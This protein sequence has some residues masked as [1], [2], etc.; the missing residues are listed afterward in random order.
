VSACTS[1][2]DA[3]S[4]SCAA[5]FCTIHFYGNLLFDTDGHFWVSAMVADGGSTSHVETIRSTGITGVPAT[6]FLTWGNAGCDG[7]TAGACNNDW[8]TPALTG[9]LSWGE[10]E[11]GTML[12]DLD[13]GLGGNDIGLMVYDKGSDSVPHTGQ[14]LWSKNSTDAHTGWPS[15]TQLS[16]LP[17]QYQTCGSGSNG[18]GGTADTTRLDD[19]R[20]SCVVD[21]ATSLIHCV[22]VNNDTSTSTQAN[23]MYFTYNH[24][25]ATKSADSTL[26]S[27]ETDGVQLSVD[28]N[29]VPTTLR[30]FY[31]E[32]HQTSPSCGT[33]PA[34]YYMKMLTNA[35][36]GGWNAAS[37]APVVSDAA[38][39]MQ[40][41]Q[42]PETVPASGTI[43]VMTE[44]NAGSSTY[45]IVV[46]TVKAVPPITKATGTCT[47]RD[48]DSTPRVSI[49]DAFITEGDSGTSNM[50][51]TVSLNVPPTSGTLTVSYQTND[52]TALATTDYTGTSGV[53]T[54]T[55]PTTSQQFTV[56][57]IGD[58][59]VE[60][61][62]SE[63]FTVTIAVTSPPTTG[64]IQDGSGTGTIV[65]NDAAVAVGSKFT[66]VPVIRGAAINPQKAPI[67]TYSSAAP[68]SCGT[69]CF[70]RQITVTCPGLDTIVA[71]VQVR[72]KVTT[73]PAA[74]TVV[75]FTGAAGTALWS[76]AGVDAAQTILD[77]NTAGFRTVEI[78]YT[79][80]S[81]ANG[82]WLGYTTASQDGLGPEA[83]ACR[84]ATLIQWAYDVQFAGA[85]ANLG[86]CGV[87]S[88]GGGSALLFAMQIYGLGSLFDFAVFDS[89]PAIADLQ[90]G[91]AQAAPS[92]SV[93][94]YPTGTAKK[95]MDTSFKYVSNTGPCSQYN[96]GS[97]TPTVYDPKFRASG[98]YSTQATED[99]GVWAFSNTRLQ[100]VFGDNDTL[101]GCDSATDQNCT[102]APA[103]GKLVYNR[104][105]ARG[106]PSGMISQCTFSAARN[107]GH[108][109][110]S[111]AVGAQYIEDLLINNCTAQPTGINGNQTA[112]P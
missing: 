1:S 86:F 14:L 77:L 62:S 28:T 53:L 7:L 22:Y 74:G 103:H 32:N 61:P 64:V 106:Q 83:S 59:A 93:Y 73:T 11:K 16:A 97:F 89:G 46:R 24:S 42:T 45:D 31:I 109:V 79:T 33:N 20:A 13:N 102:N 6:D 35:S 85:G 104:L 56:P 101:P 60:S 58:L 36:L 34:N 75:F 40:Y 50:T 27:G 19:R 44:D 8:T 69:R 12:I 63:F 43:L 65:D 111:S 92:A 110:N 84:P 54:F 88:S 38:S 26:Y 94:G 105:V 57:I 37:A 2:T 99:H 25:T 112:C 18:S 91:C 4:A 95:L 78:G 29:T 66:G 41:P 9:G 71:N 51:F 70:N 108:G 15:F 47:I 17:N 48:N 72:N 49:N 107:V 39:R 96:T 81:N 55:P 82:G 67:G 30:A 23:L 80:P 10:G 21:P 52:G 3:V 87:G 5:G 90:G 98:N 100:F 68:T 76:T